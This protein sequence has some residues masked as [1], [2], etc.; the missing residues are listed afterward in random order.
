MAPQIRLITHY[1]TF[2][3]AISFL[4]DLHVGSCLIVCLH[5][6]FI[7]S[8]NHPGIPLHFFCNSAH[9]HRSDVGKQEDSPSSTH[10]YSQKGNPSLT[11]AVSYY[12]G[13]I[14]SIK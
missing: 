5:I 12:V 14:P 8:L 3:V 2:H 10:C 6:T 13:C 1:A 7:S 4:P 11:V 9:K